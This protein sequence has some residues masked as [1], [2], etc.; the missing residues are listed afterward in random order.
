MYLSAEA[1]CVRPE[2]KRRKSKALLSFQSIV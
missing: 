2:G 1:E